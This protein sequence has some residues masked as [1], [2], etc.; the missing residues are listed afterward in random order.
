M[1]RLAILSAL[2]LAAPAMAADPA[3]SS[4]FKVGGPG[5]GASVYGILAW[6]SG[7]GVGG[8]Y[9][10]VL[11]PEGFLKGGNGAIKRDTLDVEAGVDFV[12]Y[13]WDYWGY[14]ASYNVLRPAVGASWKL[15]FSDQLCLYPKLELGFDIAWYSRSDWGVYGHPESHTGLYADLAAGALYQVSPAMALKAELGVDGLRAGVSYRF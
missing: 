12:H 9:E 2:L 13:S 11:M 8:R 1:H 3:S 6:G 10:Q 15:W 7:L 14:N 5:A 4:G